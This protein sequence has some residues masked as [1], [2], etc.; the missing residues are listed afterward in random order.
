[1]GVIVYMKQENELIGYIHS[2]ALRKNVL[3]FL[4]KNSPARPAEIAKSINKYQPHV[5]NVL[6]AF[7]ERGLVTCITPNKRTW[8]VYILAVLGKKIAKRF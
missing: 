6:K 1:M 7:E 3:K 5:S 8:R 2:S 4:E